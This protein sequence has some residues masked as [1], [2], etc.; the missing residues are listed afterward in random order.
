M[1]RQRLILAAVSVLLFAAVVSVSGMHSVKA[2]SS[3]VSPIQLQW[4][5][6]IGSDSQPH[7]SYH[8]GDRID[9]FADYYNCAQTASVITLH[10]A[11]YKGTYRLVNFSTTIAT[12]PYGTLESDW[13]VTIPKTGPLGAY[14]YW[15]TLSQYGYPD[16]T[17][18]VSFKVVK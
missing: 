13:W 7:T 18:V 5:Q 3:C 2:A 15:L 11:V 6:V 16:Q 12:Q 8:R 4:T 10:P 1:S 17:L 9:L 14:K